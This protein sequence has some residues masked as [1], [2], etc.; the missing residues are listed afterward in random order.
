MDGFYIG[1]LIGFGVMGYREHRQIC[2]L[3]TEYQD[4]KRLIN[5]QNEKQEKI[6]ISMKDLFE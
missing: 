5:K 3:E 2:K 6:R 4:L 1:I